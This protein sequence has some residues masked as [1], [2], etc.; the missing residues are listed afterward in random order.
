MANREDREL[1]LALA[2]SANEE[3]ERQERVLG[4]A[5]ARNYLDTLVVV[6]TA[7]LSSSHSLRFECL[8]THIR[9][10]GVISL[11]ALPAAPRRRSEQAE[12][13]RISLSSQTACNIV[14][15]LIWSSSM[16]TSLPLHRH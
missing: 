4:P 12:T 16:T 15:Y 8:Y 1:E 9:S 3:R 11:T 5:S 6:P 7:F 2:L 13:V 14:S 10:R